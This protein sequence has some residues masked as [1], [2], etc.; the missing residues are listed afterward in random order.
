[1][2]SVEAGM[3]FPK[4]PFHVLC[5][6]SRAHI[7]LAP[8]INM[9]EMKTPPTGGAQPPPPEGTG[10]SQSAAQYRLIKADTEQICR[11]PF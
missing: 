6:L 11:Y 1:M 4:I 5:L 8:F 7:N 9:A 3:T 2:A 10:E